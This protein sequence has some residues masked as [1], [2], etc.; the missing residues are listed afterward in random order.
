MPLTLDDPRWRDVEQAFG[1]GEELPAMLRA[2]SA[3]PSWN[4]SWS[5][6]LATDP[7]MDL[8]A[9]I[10]DEGNVRTGAYLVVPYLLSMAQAGRSRAEQATILWLELQVV[11]DALEGVADIPATIR[12]DFEGALIGAAGMAEMCAKDRSL[13]DGTRRG[14]LAAMVL[15]SR[16]LVLGRLANGI[17][18][19]DCSRST[20]SPESNSRRHRA[21]RRPRSRLTNRPPRGASEYSATNCDVRSQSRCGRSG[22]GDGHGPRA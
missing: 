5:S 9:A 2:V 4:A 10:F 1:A 22:D 15:S 21:M 13:K 8:A 7:L 6:A 12:H 14:A 16:D 17:A 18:A 3:M 19:P 20:W 11:F